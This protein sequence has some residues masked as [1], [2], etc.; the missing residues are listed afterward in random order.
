MR[1]SL[2]TLALSR[3]QVITAE[4]TE[5]EYNRLWATNVKGTFDF[6]KRLAPLI[7]EGVPSC[8]SRCLIT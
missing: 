1:S 3:A 6:S 4:K 7:N 5:D 8:V 2:K